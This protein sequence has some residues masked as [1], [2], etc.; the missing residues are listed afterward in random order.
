MGRRRGSHLRNHCH[1]SLLLAHRLR[2]SLCTTHCHTHTLL[3]YLSTNPVVRRCVW[4]PHCSICRR[5]YCCSSSVAHS[6]GLLL[7]LTSAGKRAA[8][9]CLLCSCWQ[10]SCWWSCSPSSLPKLRN[11]ENGARQMQQ[12]RSERC[13]EH[14]AV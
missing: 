8:S 10:P 7:A 12:S 3:F 1:T 5:P 11:S 4:P 2:V 9:D 6:S 13:A 14:W